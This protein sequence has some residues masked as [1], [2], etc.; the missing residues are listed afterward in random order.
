MP[1]WVGVHV[2]LEDAV[3]GSSTRK[4]A[5]IVNQGWKALAFRC[6]NQRFFDPHNLNGSAPFTTAMESTC[7]GQTCRGQ[8]PVDPSSIGATDKGL[9]VACASIV[10]TLIST[11]S[12]S[13]LGADTRLLFFW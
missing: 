13:F 1:L 6:R 3:A 10:A 8:A 11:D 12:T 9:S 2:M 7:G 5:K 4:H